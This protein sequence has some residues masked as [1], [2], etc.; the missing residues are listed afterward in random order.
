[1]GQMLPPLTRVFKVPLTNVCKKGSD[2]G[3][4]KFTVNQ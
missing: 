2:R 4:I 1:M 3:M